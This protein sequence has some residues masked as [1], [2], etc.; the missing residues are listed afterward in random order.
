MG[1]K[2]GIAFSSLPRSC[3]RGLS[4]Q[5]TLH[6]LTPSIYGPVDEPRMSA[7]AVFRMDS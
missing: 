3:Y 6:F 7:G 5:I 1:E 2:R 4:R